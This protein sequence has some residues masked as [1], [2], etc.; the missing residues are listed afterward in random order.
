MAPP[1]T[2]NVTEVEDAVEVD[3]F[4]LQDE[5]GMDVDVDGVSV[6]SEASAP[7]KKSRS[8][9]SGKVLAGVILGG[10]AIFVIIGLAVDNFA[11]SEFIQAQS[12]S[13]G[14]GSKTAKGSKT[15]SKPGKAPK[16]GSPSSCADMVDYSFYDSEREIVTTIAGSVDCLETMPEDACCYSVLVFWGGDYYGTTFDLNDYLHNGKLHIQGC[17]GGYS[18]S[19]AYEVD[20]GVYSLTKTYDGAYVFYGEDMTFT[21]TNCDIQ[22]CLDCDSPSIQTGPSK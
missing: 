2:T 16:T 17:D 15:A 19:G 3:N 8:F 13:A 22:P 1:K 14:T 6:G 12:V 9:C 10:A 4:Q 7:N 18:F 21:D 5:E 11:K 20:A